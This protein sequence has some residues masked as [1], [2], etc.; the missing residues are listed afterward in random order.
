MKEEIKYSQ[1]L[2]RFDDG[3]SHLELNL[4]HDPK[5]YLLPS[6]ESEI[7]VEEEEEF[8]ATEQSVEVKAVKA[9]FVP[10]PPEPEPIMEISL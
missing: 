4:R 9:V 3:P 8:F 10:A 6:E 5:L 2:K 1:I 7:I